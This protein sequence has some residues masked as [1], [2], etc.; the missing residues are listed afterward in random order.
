MI[1]APS[2]EWNPFVTVSM[3]DTKYATKAPGK[4]VPHRHQ[5]RQRRNEHN[6]QSGRPASVEWNDVFEFLVSVDDIDSLRLVFRVFDRRWSS[7][8]LLGS[9]ILGTYYV[10]P[11]NTAVIHR[12]LIVVNVI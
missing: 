3:S 8:S 4:Q 5:H 12:H 1:T 2:F 9:T 6:V 10:L 7:S 11:T